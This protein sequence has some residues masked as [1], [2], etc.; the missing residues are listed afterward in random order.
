MK[1][2]ILITAVLLCIMA[3][4]I[5]A[6]C[7]LNSQ[8]ST[9]NSKVKIIGAGATFPYPQLVRWINEFE[10]THKNIK[11]EYTP[12][13]S[14]EGQRRFFDKVVDFCGSDPPLS[15]DKWLMYKGKVMQIPYVLGA[16]V[17]VYN[18]PEIGNAQLV[19]SGEILAKIY[20]G[21]IIYWDDNEIKKL[22]PTI[23]DKLPHNEI[24]VVKRADAS[25]TQ[26]I[27]TTFLYKSAP[28]IWPKEL[29][30]KLP[31]FPIENKRPGKVLGG[32]GNA[33]VAEIIR[34]TPYSIGFVEWNYAEKTG[35]VYAKIINK[36]GQAILPS[37][38]SLMSAAKGALKHLP[39]DPL[40]D[41]STDL[42]Y[43]IYADDPNAYPI[44][45]WSHLILWIEYPEDKAKGLAEF[46][47]WIIENGDK[48]IVEGYAPPPEELKDIIRNAVSI[49]SK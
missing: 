45:S 19:L 42:D 40:A 29:V 13:G 39:K 18:V 23:A 15:R 30:G 8:E 26:Q 9:Q 43:I 46:L 31:N 22:N 48:Y 6:Y 12:T 47:E 35:M 32:K 37:I 34:N 49:L 7:I 11:I 27:F 41:F 2:V 17:I 10:K 24:I 36:Y 28:T 1:K 16:V 38:D 21:D 3:A 5:I 4:S 33:G 25:G 44:T 14:G 20:K